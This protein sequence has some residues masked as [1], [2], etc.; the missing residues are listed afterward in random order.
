MRGGNMQYIITGIIYGLCLFLLPLWAY[1]KGLKDGLN[2]NRGNN[3]IE[4]IKTPMQ[5]HTERKQAKQEK[6]EQ[7]KFN[8]GLNNIFSYNAEEALHPKAGD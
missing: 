7:D 4:P 3:T 5:F 2:I 8:E 6:A 1:R